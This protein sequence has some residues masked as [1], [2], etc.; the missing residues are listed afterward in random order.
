L[1]VVAPAETAEENGD[2]SVRVTGFGVI[3]WHPTERARDVRKRIVR[4]YVER[5]WFEV[6]IQSRS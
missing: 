1:K 2:R 4:L 6:E 5:K 3:A